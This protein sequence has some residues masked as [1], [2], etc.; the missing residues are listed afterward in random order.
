[1]AYIN[2]QPQSATGMLSSLL[3]LKQAE[4]TENQN[5]RNMIYQGIKDAGN[6]VGNVIGYMKRKGAIQYLGDAKLAEMEAKLAE[7]QQELTSVQNQMRTIRAE[8]KNSLDIATY[9]GS[10]PAEIDVNTMPVSGRRTMSVQHESKD[11]Y[12]A[13][14]A[15]YPY[16]NYIGAKALGGV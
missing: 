10:V 13:G 15:N 7:L 3:G 16:R 8:D 12:D 11:T 6:V 14:P 5:R 2:Y 4:M 9:P 1:M